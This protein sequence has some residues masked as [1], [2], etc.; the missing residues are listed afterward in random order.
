MGRL[1]CQKQKRQCL[2]IL[3]F[4]VDILSKLST[5]FGV[6][7]AIY[8]GYIALQSYRAS[9]KNAASALIHTLFKDYLLLSVNFNEK[10]FAATMTRGEGDEPPAEKVA[11]IKLYVLEEMFSWT[12]REER[13][14]ARFKPFMSRAAWTE[15]QS[16]IEAWRSTIR[17]HTRQDPRSVR[18]SILNYTTCY[19]VK[20]LRFIANDWSD[21]EL[22]QRVAA[23]EHAVLNRT[24]R[25]HGD[26]EGNPPYAPARRAPT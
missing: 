26:R 15:R 11:G 3:R 1:R 21:R 23:Q 8:G 4:G 19:G 12:E 5:I 25:P 9:V 22:S 6:V 20:F 7:I 14:L 10:S 2:V 16:T 24:P 13:T 18:N 17:Y